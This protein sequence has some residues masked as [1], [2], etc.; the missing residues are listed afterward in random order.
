MAS[1]GAVP[2][3][4][5]ALHAVDEPASLGSVDDLFCPACDHAWDL[6]PGVNLHLAVCG[7][8]IYEEDYDLRA[9]EAMCTLESP[10]AAAPLPQADRGHVSPAPFCAATGSTSKT[11]RG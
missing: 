4:D 11:G 2:D 7:E 8:C 9:Y 6:H 10:A 5:E 1:V 3:R